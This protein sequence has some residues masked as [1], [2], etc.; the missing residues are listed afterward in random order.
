MVC[1]CNAR[2]HVCVCARTQVCLWVCVCVC[3]HFAGQY[4][5]YVLSEKASLADTLERGYSCY[6]IC[7]CSKMPL[8]WACCL[9]HR[10]ARVQFCLCYCTIVL[11]CIAHC[12]PPAHNV[13]TLYCVSQ[14][15]AWFTYILLVR[16]ETVANAFLRTPYLENEHYQPH[17]WTTTLYI[18]SPGHTHALCQ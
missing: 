8:F 2:V 10:Q 3:V 16:N 15:I 9:T 5:V 1:V 4:W 13:C 7:L 6:L 17:T 14:N 18:F 12:K 11:Y